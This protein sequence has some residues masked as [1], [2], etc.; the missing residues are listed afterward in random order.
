MNHLTCCPNIQLGTGHDLLPRTDTENFLVPV[1]SSIFVLP[2]FICE[3]SLANFCFVIWGQLMNSHIIAGKESKAQFLCLLFQGTGAR[4]CH[5][6][7][8]RTRKHSECCCL[9]G[10]LET[11]IL[12]LAHVFKTTQD[13]AWV[14][15]SLR[16]SYSARWI[17]LINLTQFFLFCPK[18]LLS[19]WGHPP[20]LE[21]LFPWL[22][23]RKCLSGWQH[24]LISDWWKEMVSI[25]NFVFFIPRPLFHSP[26]FPGGPQRYL[27]NAFLFPSGFFHLSLPSPPPKRIHLSSVLTHQVLTNSWPLDHG[28]T[29]RDFK[30][31]D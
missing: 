15:L 31:I 4:A 20:R 30:D 29:L 16:G 11:W 14:C 19:R 17:Q 26:S 25:W 27:H 13:S 2:V 12:C 5:E 18:A 3:V 8:S 24:V 6:P 7:G 1:I 10:L 22:S 23:D 28:L 9:W 21:K